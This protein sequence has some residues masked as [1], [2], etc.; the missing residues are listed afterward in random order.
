MFE[1]LKDTINVQG[2]LNDEVTDFRELRVLIENHWDG[3]DRPSFN[4]IDFSVGKGEKVALIGESGAGK[5]S[6]MDLII[7]LNT[8]QDGSL[9]VS[10]GNG[11]KV[12]KD[13]R[14]YVSLVPQEVYK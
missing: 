5:S 1:N 14:G 13:L 2:S 8:I 11:S 7:G 10:D 6:L 9:T 12:V 4:K 3:A